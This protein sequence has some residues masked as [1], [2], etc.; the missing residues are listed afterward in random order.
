[1]VR[2]LTCGAKH[3]CDSADSA[4]KNG[5]RCA[6]H[7]CLSACVRPSSS[8]GPLHAQS[9]CRAHP[10]QSPVVLAAR[11]MTR[12]RCAIRFQVEGV[13]ERGDDPGDALSV[14]GDMGLTAL[15]PLVMEFR[16]RSA[17]GAGGKTR[18]PYDVSVSIRQVSPPP[19]PRP[20]PPAPRPPPPPPF[21]L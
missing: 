14:S 8:R 10:R 21:P 5:M 4:A 9:W 2:K 7:A 15:R 16:G 18:P 6:Q 17:A 20:P 12:G 11:P 13:A 19:A 3:V 1:M